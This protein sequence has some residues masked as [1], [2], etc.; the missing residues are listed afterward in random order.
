M[1]STIESLVTMN[2]I[3]YNRLS[4]IVGEAYK[5]SSSNQLDFFIDINS[6]IKPLFSKDGMIRYEIEDPLSLCAA[7]INMCAHYRSFFRNY[8]V[9]TS[10]Y[11]VFSWNHPAHNDKFVRG[12]NHSFIDSVMS[13]KPM[14]DYVLNNMEQ[15]EIICPYL[16]NIKFYRTEFETSCCIN[17]LLRLNNPDELKRKTCI[18]LSKD[19]LNMQNI[20]YFPDNVAYLRPLKYDGDRSYICK[21]NDRELPIEFWNVFCKERK[22]KPFEFTNNILSPAYFI[23]LVALSN[24]KSRNIYSIFPYRKSLDICMQYAYNMIN[25]DT[26]PDPLIAPRVFADFVSRTN[27][28]VSAIAIEGNIKAIDSSYQH[29]IFENTIEAKLIRSIRSNLYD[30]NG[31]Q[32]INNQYFQKCPLDLDSL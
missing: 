10:F 20:A 13:N 26:L 27:D 31:V 7:I 23:N 22:I 5:N 21:I 29:F 18:I 32:Y 28:N 16:P 1:I 3:K 11:L 24:C 15:L 12:Y 30:K 14:M 8:Q 19:I 17:E 2:Y 4:E 9:Q 6:I 25:Q